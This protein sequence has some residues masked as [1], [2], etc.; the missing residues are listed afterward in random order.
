VSKPYGN[1]NLLHGILRGTKGEKL[2]LKIR[3]K[4]L[5]VETAQDMR[6]MERGGF[7]QSYGVVPVHIVI[8]VVIPV[9]FSLAASEVGLNHISGAVYGVPGLLA[10]ASSFLPIK[11][12]S[13][14]RTGN[15]S[16]YV[17]KR[18]FKVYA[19]SLLAGLMMS[20]PILARNTNSHAKSQADGKAKISVNLKERPSTALP[21]MP[22]GRKLSGISIRL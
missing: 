6:R 1:Y 17:R 15:A 10:I 20:T 18:Q 12:S 14:R 16:S 13:V 22:D 5:S 7:C 3:G 11:K 8:N 2:F 21:V 9:A 4:Q 19:A